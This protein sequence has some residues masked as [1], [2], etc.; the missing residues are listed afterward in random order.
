MIFLFNW[1]ILFLVSMVLPNGLSTHLGNSHSSSSTMCSGCPWDLKNE[2]NSLSYD[3]CPC[4][5]ECFRING[6]WITGVFFTPPKTSSSHLKNSAGTKAFLDFIVSKMHGW[7]FGSDDFLFFNWEMFRF[8]PFIF[9]GVS[10]QKT[11]GLH[12]TL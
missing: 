6:D 1:V 8:Q 10:L 9:K 4:N 3:K 12:G 2:Q 7:R 11:T 5:W